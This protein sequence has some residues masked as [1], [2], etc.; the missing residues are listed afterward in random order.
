MEKTIKNRL[1]LLRKSLA[2]KKFDTLMVIVEENRRYL[3]GFTGEDTQFDE[4]AGALFITDSKLILAT[5]S[6]YELQ[7]KNEAPLFEI[8]CYKELAK[9][10]PNIANM[11]G[12][13]RLGFESVRMSFMQYS[14][15]ASE[16]NA[17]GMQVELV[18][19]E[20][21]VENLRLI[22]DE[23]EIDTLKKALL[24][25][26]SVFKHIKSTIKPGMTER[27]LAWAMEKEMREAGAQSLSFPTIVASGPNSAFPHAMPSDR[28]FKAGEPILFDWGARLDG[29]CSDISRTVIIGPPDKTFKKVFTTLHDAQRMATD[30][31]KPGMSSKAVDKIARDH[32]EN[33]GFKGKF[34][35]GLGH[36]TGLAVHEGPRISTLKDIKL[37]QGMVFTVE[38]G[39]YIPGWGGIRLE[40][41]VVVRDNGVEVLNKID[42]ADFLIGI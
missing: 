20:D 13:K 16:L 8:V 38:P 3:C 36:G 23:T 15:M 17:A 29:Y 35:H 1:L 39:I 14:K 42:P 24:I 26:E 30:A 21:I 10:L 22:K 4:S 18:P 41:M 5:D 34:G 31:I 19:A 40:N 6:R 11:L 7:A 12:I 27:Q 33:S 37:E 32:I 9:E 2:E 28:K 25:A